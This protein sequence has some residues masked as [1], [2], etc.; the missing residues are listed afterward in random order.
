MSIA[1]DQLGDIYRQISERFLSHPFISVAPTQGDPPD[2]Y[3]IT[4]KISG[5]TEDENGEII[6][7]GDH[8]VEL[9]IPFGFPHFPPSCRPKSIIFH[10]DFDPGAICIGDYWE[11]NP[12]LIDLIIQIG[13]MINGESYSSQDAFNEKAAGWY[14]ENVDKFPLAKIAWDSVA[15]SDDELIEEDTF[16]TLDVE[17]LSFDAGTMLELEDAEQDTEVSDLFPPIELEIESDEDVDISSFQGLQ[18]RKEF[19][20]LRRTLE[21]QTEFSN[22]LQVLLDDTENIIADGELLYKEAQ[23]LEKHGNASEALDKYKEVA[24]TIS[25]YPAIRSDI[26]R[27]DQTLSLVADLTPQDLPESIL[28]PVFDGGIETAEAIIEKQAI[29]A[30]EPENKKER[31]APPKVAISTPQKRS[32]NKLLL[33]G[34]AVGILLLVGGGYTLS[35]LADK[36]LKD[37]NLSYKNCSVA[38]DGKNY[39]NAKKLCESGLETLEKIWFFRKGEAEGLSTSLA[40]IL[41]SDELKQGIEGNVF[42]DGKY[43]SKKEAIL[44]QDLRAKTEEAEDL[45]LL[46]NF[47]EASNAYLEALA[48]AEKIETKGPS[49]IEKLERQSKRADFEHF[50][51]LTISNIGNKQWQE[52]LQSIAESQTR[53]LELPEKVQKEFE[54]P[55]VDMSTLCNFEIALS[56]ADSAMATGEWDYAISAYNQSLDYALQI[57]DLQKS[58]I[59]EVENSIA[60]AELYKTLEKGNNAFGTGNW[61]DAIEAYK[62]ANKTLAESQNVLLNEA[63][64]N[65]NR[66]K[67]NKIILQAS[68]IRDQQSIKSMLSND[69]LHSARDAYKNLLALIENS[70]LSGET[71][72]SKA[73]KDIQSQIEKLQGKIYIA[74]KQE[75]LEQNYQDLFSTN[76]ENAVR[77]NL[78]APV[79]KLTKETPSSLVFRLQ[80]TEKRRGRSLTLVMFYSYDKKSGQW[81]LSAGS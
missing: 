60:R 63:K 61:D 42:V 77:E 54:A 17:E 32:I 43:V 39:Q 1:P 70:S 23:D 48:I 13:Q 45:Y 78:T 26:K 37:A 73:K 18:Q 57:P 28:E 53:L 49:V 80:C 8:T 68:I 19:F 71:E 47:Q 79:V 44:I 64:S 76:Y 29:E 21:G 9:S 56:G 33:I 16:D 67:L 50:H 41:S 40:N 4:Y 52:A 81:S 14:E 10:P 34:P 2:Q 25:D 38:L 46:K 7:V 3:S 11:Q 5:L 65:V 69:E 75:Y 30:V 58:R 62:Q 12:S 6:E 55:L 27:L 24:S 22:E 36:H 20:S 51:L 31:K 74:D 72:F 15:E 59:D 35:F 66:K